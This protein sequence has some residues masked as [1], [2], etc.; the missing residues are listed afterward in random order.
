[1]NDNNAAAAPLSA[2]KELR[3]KAFAQARAAAGAIRQAA[4]AVII[5]Q[6]D[7]IDQTL[8]ALLARG[9]VLLEGVPGTG[10][11]LLVRTLARLI[12]AKFSRIQFTPD[13][14]PSDVTGGYWFNQ[15]ENRFELRPG[16]VFSNLLLADEINR[17]PAKT[18]AALLE[19]MQERS[20]TLDGA[21][22]PL[23]EPFMT[24]A[25]QNPIEQEG[26][27]PLPE[28]QLDRFLLKIV[29]DYPQ[30]SEEIELLESVSS[31]PQY[32]LLSKA[33]TRPVLGCKHVQ[34][35]QRIAASV[36]ID[37][38]VLSYIARLVRRTRDDPAFA[39][40]AGPRAGLAL[41]ACCKA[42]ALMAGRDFAMPQDVKSVFLAA[43][44]HRVRLSTE[45]EMEGGTVD[46]A[47][48]LVLDSIVAPRS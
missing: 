28:A 1:M 17:A 8:C 12:D 39:A 11:T 22:K 2:E 31:A 35:L 18:Q 24:L 42:K 32:D 44:R 14:M 26:T 33:Q 6:D 13:L 3:A 30:E 41:M 5:G 7:A 23:P 47:L 25:T 21:T 34:W 10:K 45:M 20:V 37:R 4:K 19:S 15:A 43:M 46:E 38:S 27:Y 48:G 16:P 9:H 29:I 36:T 40:G